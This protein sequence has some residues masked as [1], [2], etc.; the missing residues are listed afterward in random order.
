MRGIGGIGRVIDQEYDTQVRILLECRRE[1]GLPDDALVL[2]VGGNND[3]HGRYLAIEL[4]VDSGARDAAMGAKALE[5]SQPSQEIR[6]GRTREEGDEDEVSAG[7]DKRAE[8]DVR[9]CEP[10]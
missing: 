3:G 1:H 8:T 2:A 7:L 9:A 4:I 10:N 5:V 6:R